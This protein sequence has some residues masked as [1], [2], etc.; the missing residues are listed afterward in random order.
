[1]TAGALM[2]RANSR[3]SPSVPPDRQAT[4]RP[5]IPQG[6]RGSPSCRAQNS[7]KLR[8]VIVLYMA[9]AWGG[10]PVRGPGRRTRA[11]LRSCAPPTRSHPPR[12]A[13]LSH[14]R[15]TSLARGRGVVGV[16][17]PV[18]AGGGETDRKERGNRLQTARSTE[19]RINEFRKFSKIVSSRDRVLTCGESPILFPCS[20]D[21][22][23]A[24]F[25]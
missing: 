9:A 12:P 22:L 13:A 20:F 10:C 24:R 19:R 11:R 18:D 25:R 14:A 3:R 1:M 4:S 8:R 5:S 17:G 23:F 6:D 2:A 7:Q 16:G 21:P 15:L